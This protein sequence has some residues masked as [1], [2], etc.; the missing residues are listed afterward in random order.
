MSNLMERDSGT[1][2]AD[3]GLMENLHKFAQTMAGSAITVPKHLQGNVGDC[4]AICMQSA[5]WGMNP[6]SVAQKTHIVNGALGYEAQL[7]IAIVTTSGAITG[8]FKFEFQGDFTDTKHGMVRC[9]AVLK[10]E[11]EITWGEWIDCSKLKVKNSPLWKQQPKQQA[12]YYA[13]KSWTRLNTPEVILG[14]YTPDEL[15]QNTQEIKDVSRE[16]SSFKD[17]LNGSS[18]VVIESNP[19]VVPNPIAIEQKEEDIFMNLKEALN[20]CKTKEELDEFGEIMKGQKFENDAL[21]QELRD[22]F[23]DKIK[24]VKK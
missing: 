20:N 24:T 13:A 22:G 8:R 1:M 9:G 23:M 17:R 3:V 14:I 5:Q 2:M 4:M 21:L 10:G 7:V 15:E 11:E 18:D 16:T 12:S 19:V 6:F